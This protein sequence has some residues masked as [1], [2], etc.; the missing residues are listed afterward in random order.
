MTPFGEYCA[1]T[2]SLEYLGDRWSLLIVRNLALYGP[3]GFNA[4][5][6]SLPG[7]S[8]PVLVRRL[9]SDRSIVRSPP[10]SLRSLDRPP[11]FLRSAA[12]RDI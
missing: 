6:D 12:D 11:E 4:I 10:M 2:K 1:F 7:I 5:A 9:R 3:Q 8:R